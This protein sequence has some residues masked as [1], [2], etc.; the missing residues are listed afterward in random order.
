M[1]MVLWP[2][3]A[4]S[5]PCDSGS[6]ALSRPCEWG[7][8]DAVRDSR[9]DAPQPPHHKVLPLPP[10]QGLQLSP[11]YPKPPLS[12][13]PFAHLLSC[14]WRDYFARAVIVQGSFFSLE[15]RAGLRLPIIQ[16]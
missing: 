16:C 15:R 5:R 3:I 12:S 13:S 9:R 10:P 6:S 11:A 14:Q 1:L 7:R 4:V 2:V 8:G